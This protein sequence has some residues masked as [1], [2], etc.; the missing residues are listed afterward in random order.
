MA[1]EDQAWLTH[2]RNGMTLVLVWRCQPSKSSLTADCWSALVTSSYPSN[3][4]G[5]GPD[6]QPATNRLLL[7]RAGG[8]G[9][10]VFVSPW[11]LSTCESS[12]VP[13]TTS[14]LRYSTDNPHQLVT[15]PTALKTHSYNSV[16]RSARG[17]RRGPDCVNAFRLTHSTD[18]SSQSWDVLL[19]YWQALQ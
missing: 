17:E 5:A 13:T 4:T 3:A 15:W 8:S 19:F 1:L 16:R 11:L 10:L 18:H 14:T 2:L 12:C 9:P 7:I 6:H